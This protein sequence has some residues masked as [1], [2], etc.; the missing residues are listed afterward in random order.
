MILDIVINTINQR[1]GGGTKYTNQR[2]EVFIQSAFI[3]EKY[4]VQFTD[5]LR[6]CVA[7]GNF[8][9]AIYTEVL[10]LIASYERGF[11]DALQRACK[12]KGF[13]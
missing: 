10:D 5:A 1:T 9:Y 11:A 7:M 4:R 3:E 2:D 13:S 8:K 6:D 12:E